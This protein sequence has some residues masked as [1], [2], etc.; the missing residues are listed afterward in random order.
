MRIAGL[1]AAVHSR[2]SFHRPAPGIV[3]KAKS[4]PRAVPGLGGGIIHFAAGGINADG[5]IT[6]LTE[7]A[8]QSGNKL[9]RR[10]VDADHLQVGMSLRQGGGTVCYPVT[11]LDMGTVFAGKADPVLCIQGL[12]NLSF[13][14]HLGQGWLSL[15]ISR[16]QPA[17]HSSSMRR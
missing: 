2:C 16:S 9:R 8:N 3:P 1:T 17:F 15:N 7:L 5:Q 11:L 12:G 6:C 4:C 14:Q 13:N 10:A